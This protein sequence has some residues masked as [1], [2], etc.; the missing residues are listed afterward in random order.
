MRPSDITDGITTGDQ[1]DV[2]VLAET[3][4]MR[5]SDIT[6]GICSAT[7]CVPV[8]LSRLQ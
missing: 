7:R 3:A 2:R 8:L 1:L 5:P 4:S 6:D